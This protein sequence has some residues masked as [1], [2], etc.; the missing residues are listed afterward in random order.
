MNF[1]LINTYVKAILSTVELKK[2]TNDLKVR[3]T[4]L[5]KQTKTGYILK[6]SH[7]GKCWN[8]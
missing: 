6:L 8:F 4:F 5:Q 3:R 2:L 7:T 1:K